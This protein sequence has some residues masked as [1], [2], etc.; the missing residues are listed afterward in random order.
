[1]ASQ[2]NSEIASLTGLRGVA[3]LCVVVAHYA[4]M[5]AV[6]PVAVLPRWIPAWG[7]IC[8]NV[9][10]SIFFTLSGFVIALSYTAWDW[11]RHPAF[12]PAGGIVYVG[13]IS[14]SLYLFHFLTPNVI[15]PGYFQTFDPSIIPHYIMATGPIDF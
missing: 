4:L 12:N 6:T 3:A 15:S 9:G 14:Y 7:G 5:T 10:M 2:T 8:S 1:M 11:K 13:T